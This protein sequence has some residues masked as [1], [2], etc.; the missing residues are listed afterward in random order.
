V[1]PL[2][3]RHLSEG[4]RLGKYEVLRHIATGSLAELYLARVVGIDDIDKLIVIKRLLPQYVSNSVFV[5]TFLNEARLSATL[6]HQNI[7]QVHDL[8]IANGNFFFA[9]EYVHG[10]D[11]DRITIES[12]AMRVPISTTR[13]P[14]RPSP[15]SPSGPT[16]R[17]RPS[18]ST[19]T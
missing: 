2:G 8:G 4:D 15:T 7:A 10:E 5:E 14:P 11:L 9:M 18:T 19:S 3:T 17:F 6:Q 16:S 12:Q 13:R 1:L